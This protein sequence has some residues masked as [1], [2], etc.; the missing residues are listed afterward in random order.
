MSDLLYVPLYV[1]SDTIIVITLDIKHWLL[2][3]VCL[4]CC[5]YSVILSAFFW[6]AL[7]SIYFEAQYII[8]TSINLIE[9]HIL[10]LIKC[11]IS[12]FRSCFVYIDY[13]YCIFCIPLLSGMGK[14][15]AWELE[16]EF[17]GNGNDVKQNCEWEWE[18]RYGNGREWEL[19][20]HSRSRLII[21]YGCWRIVAG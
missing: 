2:M 12:L 1:I 9:S 15:S 16:M 20:N 10:S 13:E 7:Y 17:D 14:D 19:K 18:C 11:I 4:Q 8:Y 21:S 6:C 5:S 3:F